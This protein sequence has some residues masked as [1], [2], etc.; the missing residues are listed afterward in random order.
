M[1][2]MATDTPKEGDVWQKT[3]DEWYIF[4]DGE[5][6]LMTLEAQLAYSK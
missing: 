6:Q 3:C 4:I 1:S 2:D 5:W